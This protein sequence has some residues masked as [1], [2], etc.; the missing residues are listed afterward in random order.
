MGGNKYGSDDLCAE[1][2]IVFDFEVKVMGGV[3]E[4]DVE[5]LVPFRV[6]RVREDTCTGEGCLGD[7]EGDV[8]IAGDDVAASG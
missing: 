2:V 4:R 1:N 8:R 3:S 5:M 7:G 6:L